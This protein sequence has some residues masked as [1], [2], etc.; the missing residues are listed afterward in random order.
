M[1]NVKWEDIYQLPLSVDKVSNYVWAKNGTMALMFNH[2]V[3]TKDRQKIVD[4]INNKDRHKILGLKINNGDFYIDKKYIFCVRGW[5][6]L[7][8]RGALNL[9]LNEA[10]KIQDNFIQYVHSKLN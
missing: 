10:E 4:S 3:N 5:G 9:H 8:G 7:V 1:K 6:N 2:D